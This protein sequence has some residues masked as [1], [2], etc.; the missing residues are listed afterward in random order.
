MI[1]SL[2]D[3]NDWNY[4]LV[5]GIFQQLLQPLWIFIHIYKRKRPVLFFKVCHD[6]LGVRAIFLTKYHIVR[7]NTPVRMPQRRGDY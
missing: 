6:L 7:H 2:C 1:T 4:I 5:V 3:D